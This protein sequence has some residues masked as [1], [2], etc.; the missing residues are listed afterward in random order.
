MCGKRAISKAFFASRCDLYASSEFQHWHCEGTS[1]IS[2]MGNAAGN[3]ALLP[4]SSTGRYVRQR[5]HLVTPA[6]QVMDE[7]G[8]LLP[9]CWSQFMCVHGLLSPSCKHHAYWDLLLANRTRRLLCPLGPTRN[10]CQL[11]CSSGQP[12]TAESSCGG[13]AHLPPCTS[14][15]EQ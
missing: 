6:H 14:S 4:R 13:N 8:A 3:A 11:H 10:L 1:R 2:C 7:L 9:S 12:Q 15:G 5:S